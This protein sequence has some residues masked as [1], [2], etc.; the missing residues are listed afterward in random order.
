MVRKR[1]CRICGRWFQPAGR[2]G[3]RQHVCSR[4]ECQRERHRRACADWRAREADAERAE[5]VRRR[6]EV[7]PSK[8]VSAGTGAGRAPPGP[9][10]RVQWDAVRDA[11]GM[12]VAVVL[13]VFA[14]VLGDWA[15]DAV[16]LQVCEATGKTRQVVPT[17]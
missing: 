7:A 5:R 16:R 13:Q 3:D 8:E 10:A 12:E 4:A 11:V 15:R 1:P 9:E 6:V 2:A 14:R 17:G